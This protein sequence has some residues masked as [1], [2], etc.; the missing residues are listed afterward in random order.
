MRSRKR[1]CSEELEVDLKW[2][3]YKVKYIS[4]LPRKEEILIL[5]K[6]KEVIS[7]GRKL[8]SKEYTPAPVT[9]NTSN[10]IKGSTV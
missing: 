1:K 9:M 10:T 2:K 7:I 3:Q 4:E 8:W 5:N 6:N